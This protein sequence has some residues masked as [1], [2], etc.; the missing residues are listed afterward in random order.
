MRVGGA[1]LLG[2]NLPEFFSWKANAAAK[3][4]N[5]SKAF[6]GAK[7]V[8]MLF[9]QGGPSHIDIWDPKP[10]APSEICGEFKAIAT[11]VSGVHFGEHMP[12][13]A[14]ILDRC[15]L[16]RS[17][18]HNIPDHAPGAQYL[19]TGNKPSAALEH[20]SLGAIAARLLPATDGIPP[21][22]TP[23]IDL[24]QNPPQDPSD[25]QP[26]RATVENG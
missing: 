2:L 14:G 6:G 21:F 9:L 24:A 12:R 15:L 5:P 4:D 26:S 18:H 17:L 13:T 7:S 19:M 16:V 3:L 25:R 22:F 10:E 1:T 20:P 8:I 23:S 11:A